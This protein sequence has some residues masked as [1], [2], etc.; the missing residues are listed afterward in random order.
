MIMRSLRVDREPT[1]SYI[2][3]ALMAHQE[4]LVAQ[5][6]PLWRDRGAFAVLQVTLVA[7]RKALV[8]HQEAIMAR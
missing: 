5:Q 2:H 8:G 4:A 7:N 6:G 1:L 3:G